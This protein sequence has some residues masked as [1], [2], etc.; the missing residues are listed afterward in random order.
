MKSAL[1]IM[2]VVFLKILSRGI[3]RFEIGCNA[4]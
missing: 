4:F 2:A 3:M 1:L